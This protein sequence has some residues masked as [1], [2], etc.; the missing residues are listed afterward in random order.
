MRELTVK[1]LLDLIVADVPDAPGRIQKVFEWHFERVK[2]TAQW[3]L[4]AAASLFV[5]SLIPFF[6]AELQLSWWQTLLLFL[7]AAGTASYGIYRLW[8]LRTLHR[9]FVAAL[10][11]HSE[12]KQM[13]PFFLRYR[14]L[15][16]GG[17][18]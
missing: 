1:D 8:Q 7:S 6:K 14:A 15:R 13:R 16:N 18:S 12:F 17:S 3:V 11:L 9:E 5:S 4:G 2:T 10:K